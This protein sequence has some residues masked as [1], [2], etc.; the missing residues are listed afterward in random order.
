VMLGRPGNLR[1]ES[2]D[3]QG[4]TVGGADRPITVTAKHTGCYTY[5]ADACTAGTIYGMCGNSDT[6]LIISAN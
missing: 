6:Q 3:H 4:S 1:R 2:F 5:S